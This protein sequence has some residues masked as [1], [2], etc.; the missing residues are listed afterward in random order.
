M[1][2]IDIQVVEFNSPI[3]LKSVELRYKVLR[4]PLG[5]VYT[6]EQLADEK[7]VAHIVALKQ[8]EVVGVLLLKV[9][10][11]KVLKMRQVAVA[12]DCQHSGIGKLLVFFAEQYAKNNGFQ[13]IELHARDTAKDFYLKLNYKVEGN[14][15]MEV[16]I[17]HYK[18]KKVL[19]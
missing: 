4:E 7:D 3:Q 12:T 2:N 11:A 17:P 18:M 19:V 14:V 1:E 10:G 8:D 5:L 16:G 9:A 15:F 13:L 6:P